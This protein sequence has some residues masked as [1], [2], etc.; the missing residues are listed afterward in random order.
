M[1][2]GWPT[3]TG[4]WRRVRA[5]LTA[6]ALPSCLLL[7]DSWT[8]ATAM[9]QGR[10]PAAAAD[11]SSRR[12]GRHRPPASRFWFARPARPENTTMCI[13]GFSSLAALARSGPP[14]GM[15]TSRISTSGRRSLTRCRHVCTVGCL[16]DDVKPGHGGQHR[17]DGVAQ[18]LVVVADDHRAQESRSTG[19][20]RGRSLTGS[21]RRAASGT[22]GSVKRHHGAQ[23]GNAF[24]VQLP[25]FG[26]G[27]GPHGGHPEVP[28]AGIQAAGPHPVIGQADHDQP[29]PL[30]EA[31]G[32]VVRVGVLADVAE[33]L[34]EDPV[35]G[36]LGRH[37]QR[38][39]VRGRRR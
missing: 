25:A 10:P 20:D 3:P 36:L 35:D 32:G 19:L 15:L 17:R 37:A 13:A 23:P 11:R 4:R 14:P 33:R 27:P 38:D 34:P 9:V 31:Q 30:L 24:D 16:A 2:A 8:A 12:T 7:C 6:A 1:S 21:A 39:V 5:G 18:V 28:G 22:A 26:F 29:V